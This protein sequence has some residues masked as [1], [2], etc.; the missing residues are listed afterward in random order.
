ML[1]IPNRLAD[2]PRD[3]E[4]AV[5]CHSGRRSARVAEFLTANGFENVV[6]VRGGIDAWSREIDP[7]VARY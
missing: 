2:I 1:D 3:R 5:L 7:A 6:N 4:I